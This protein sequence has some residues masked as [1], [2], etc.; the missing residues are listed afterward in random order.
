MVNLGY[1]AVGFRQF[2]QWQKIRALKD[3]SKVCP[4]DDYTLIVG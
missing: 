2:P 1:P 3:P 4:N